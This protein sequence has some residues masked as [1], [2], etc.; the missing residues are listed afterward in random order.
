MEFSFGDAE[1]GGPLTLGFHE[2]GHFYNILNADA[3]ALAH[4]D[5]G[6]IVS[7]TRRFSEGVPY[8]HKRSHEGI[9]R[10][11]VVRRGDATGGNPREPHYVDPGGHRRSRLSAHAAEP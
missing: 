5:F 1:L 4:P 3:C 6:K 2:K 8:Y 11:L 7:G 9:L 10:Y